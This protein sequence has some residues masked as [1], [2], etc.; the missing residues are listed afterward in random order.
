MQSHK[1]TKVTREQILVTSLARPYSL[2]AASPP[3]A[4]AQMLSVALPT[5]GQLQGDTL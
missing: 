1:I 4:R 3:W 2:S 5:L